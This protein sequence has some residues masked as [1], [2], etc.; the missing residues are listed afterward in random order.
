M[1]KWKKW[2]EK[3]IFS[4]LFVIFLC[5]FS[6]CNWY[7]HGDEIM[8]NPG[9]ETVNEELLLRYPMVEAYGFLQMMM[10]KHEENGFDRVKDKRGFLYSGNFWNGFG[11]DQKEL[12]VRVCYLR[13]QLEKTGTKTGFILWPMKLAEPEDR[14]L[15]IPYNDSTKF[16]DSMAA[17]LRYYGVPLLD[18]R[19]LKEKTGMSQEQFFFKTDHHWT[20]L[21]AFE[22]YLE[23]TDWIEE[24]YGEKLDP[25]GTLHNKENYEQETFEK[26][27]L[28][29]AGQDAGVLFS[30]GM[31]DLTL[32]YP[33]E[34][35]NY[36]LKE[37]TLENYQIKEG[38]FQDALMDMSCLEIESYEEW[39]QQ[40]A[41]EI[42][43]GNSVEQYVSI[44]NLQADTDSSVLLLRDSFAQPVGPLLAQSF[45]KVDML[46][47]LEITEE[48]LGDFLEK[49]HY[50]YV[51]FALFP[52]NLQ[53][54]AFPFGME[55]D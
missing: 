12:A 40:K 42:Y 35:G 45:R 22:G 8:E 13:E 32:I 49:N 11:E 30:G 29:S 17:W 16:G 51:F 4:I 26:V 48:E 50:D 9:E 27:M 38:S 37:G 36:R 3:E 41:G 52:E 53:S 46:W 19:E 20:P 54:D 6:V 21:A 23:I 28:G 18:L 34:K 7:V 31:E 5:G 55:E 24:T 33:K 39:Y 25:D 14:Y 15:G 2:S 1:K 10:G 44:E 47:T 43:L